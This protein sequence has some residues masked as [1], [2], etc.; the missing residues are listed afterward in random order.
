MAKIYIE[1]WKNMDGV[2]YGDA[3]TGIDVVFYNGEL[4]IRFGSE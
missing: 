1:V 3:M 4:E 2:T